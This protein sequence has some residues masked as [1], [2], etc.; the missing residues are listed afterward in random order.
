MYQNEVTTYRQ[1]IYKPIINYLCRVQAELS[2]SETN[3]KL[4]I[5]S[6]LR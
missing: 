1:D 5:L 2:V 6:L 4:F 3:T